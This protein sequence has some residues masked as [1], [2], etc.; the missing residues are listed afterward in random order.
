[1]I[2]PIALLDDMLLYRD[3]VG[4]DYHHDGCGDLCSDQF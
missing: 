2:H 3:D 4:V 1:M